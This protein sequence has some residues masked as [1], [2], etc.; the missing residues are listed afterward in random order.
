MTALEELEKLEEREEQA[1]NARLAAAER[2]I[3][4]LLKEHSDAD[5]RELAIVALHAADEAL[6]AERAKLIQAWDC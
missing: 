5:A 3:Q 1:W 4:D 6:N 2:A